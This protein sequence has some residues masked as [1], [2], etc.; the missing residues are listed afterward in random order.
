MSYDWPGNV[1]ELQNALERAVVMGKTDLI[2]PEDLPEGCW[3][4]AL[5]VEAAD[6]ILQPAMS[7]RSRKAVSD[8]LAQTGRK[9]HEGG[10]VVRGAR[11]LSAPRW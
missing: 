3:N 1:R 6:G 2:L 5:Q 8:S 10:A 7:R 4:R 11:E 9:I